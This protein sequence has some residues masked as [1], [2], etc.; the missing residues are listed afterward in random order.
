MISKELLSE[1]LEEA[2]DFWKIST[3]KRIRRN[4]LYIELGTFDGDFNEVSINI[5]ELAHDC[6][7]WASKLDRKKDYILNS[8]VF[9]SEGYCEVSTKGQFSKDKDFISS[10]EPE[11][12]F[13]ACEWIFKNKDK[14]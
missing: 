4:E 14:E 8:Y 9:D 3:F 10:T 13:K 7:E 2:D 12:V 11:A 1:V 6:K 5:Y